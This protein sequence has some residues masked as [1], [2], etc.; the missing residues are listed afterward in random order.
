MTFQHFYLCS[1]N[2]CKV[3]VVAHWVA[4]HACELMSLSEI[5]ILNKI[6]LVIRQKMG[7]M[8]NFGL[9]S[10]SY[11]ENI[12]RP[13]PPPWPHSIWPRPRAQLAS[14]K[15]LPSLRPYLAFRSSLSQSLSLR[16]RFNGFP[17]DIGR[18]TNLLTYLLNG[19]Y[20]YITGVESALELWFTN[21][22][23]WGGSLDVPNR[24]WSLGG[25]YFCP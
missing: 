11:I 22:K 12:F 16:I 13:R 9:A 25:G 23:V 21:N 6:M 4:N 8:S 2:Y 24:L 19:I 5:I 7:P 1:S 14:L 20:I 10:A 18:H 3:G 15:S 17:V